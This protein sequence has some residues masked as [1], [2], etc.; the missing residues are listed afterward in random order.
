VFGLLPQ[1][2][3]L[4][5]GLGAVAYVIGWREATAFY[6]GLGAPWATSLL[7]TSQVTRSSIWIVSMIG[8]FF[9]L[10]VYMLTQQSTSAKSLR[11]WSVLFMGI[12]AALYI[13]FFFVPPA[14][15]GLFAAGMSMCWS[16]S[17]GLTLGELVAS[18]ATSKMQWH[19]YHVYLLYFV[20]TFG[21]VFVSDT[22]GSLRAKTILETRGARLAEVKI[23]GQIN[24]SNWRLVAPVGSELL[25]VSF[26]GNSDKHKFVITAVRNVNSIEATT[27]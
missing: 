27:N 13:V 26:P 17:T 4:V 14:A 18:L 10:S 25:V 3:G 23:N 24:D 22:L 20:V 21:L 7:T 2:A 6:N 16:C 9:V 8:L 11:L 1:L 5:V 19:A 12:A 15:A